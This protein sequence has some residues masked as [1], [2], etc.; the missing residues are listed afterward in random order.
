MTASTLL[1][2]LCIFLKITTT[3]C[4]KVPQGLSFPLGVCGLCATQYFQKALIRDSDNLVKPFMQVAIQT[5]RYY[6][7]L[8]TLL[9]SFSKR[10]TNHNFF[11]EIV[12]VTYFYATPYVSIRVGLYLRHQFVDDVWRIVSEDTRII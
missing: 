2:I 4:S 7:T 12:A 3:S 5:T 8:S 10:I 11:Y 9:L 1:P 6:V